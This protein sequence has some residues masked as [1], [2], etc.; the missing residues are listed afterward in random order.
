MSYRTQNRGE[1]MRSL[2]FFSLIMVVAACATTPP[3]QQSEPE[4]KLPLF[5]EK[6][7]SSFRIDDSVVT[8]ENLEAAEEMIRV[9]IPSCSNQPV[10]LRPCL[11]GIAIYK[12]INGQPD[13]FLVDF[14]TKVPKGEWTF[15]LR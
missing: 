11:Y 10:Q 3:I 14:R 1:K 12:R 4:I 13:E 7:I 8:F 9:E 6:V 15:E 2:M 5:E